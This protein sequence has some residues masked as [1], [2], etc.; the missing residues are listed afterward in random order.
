MNYILY[1]L[2]GVLISL[3]AAYFLSISR[4]TLFWGKE[5][6]NEET[7]T[8]IQDA[9]TPPWISYLSI[10]S[11][12]TV[13]IFIIIGFVLFGLLKGIILIP[14]AFL[15]TGIITRVLP[16]GNSIF[17]KNIIMRSLANRFANFTKNR[18]IVRANAVKDILNKFGMPVPEIL[19]NEEKE[20][21]IGMN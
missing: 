18:D 4:A 3:N 16:K 7:G 17:Y 1:L 10:G 2:I 21:E 9:I 12:V 20:T 14:F 11:Y 6:V 19:T 5:L 15:A 13:L 8:G